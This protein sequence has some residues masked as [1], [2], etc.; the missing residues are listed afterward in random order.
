M[1][2]TD[3]EVT[4]RAVEGSE[5][6]TKAAPSLP[7]ACAPLGVPPALFLRGKTLFSICRVALTSFPAAQVQAFKK[8]FLKLSDKKAYRIGFIAELE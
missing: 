1:G 8:L 3:L 5:R 4:V 7:G 2:A 6:E